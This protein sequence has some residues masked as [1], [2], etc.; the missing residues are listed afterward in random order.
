MRTVSKKYTRIGGNYLVVLRIWGELGNLNYFNGW[1]PHA[2]K[3]VIGA[4]TT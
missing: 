1:K 2:T 4:E 3:V